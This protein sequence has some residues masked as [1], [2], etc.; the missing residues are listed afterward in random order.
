MSNPWTKKNPFM[1]VWLS[2]ANALL[3]SARSRTVAA[4]RRQAVAMTAAGTREMMKLWPGGGVSAKP[5]RR[6]KKAR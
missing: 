6:R 1:S 4:A 2:G 5:K 3:G